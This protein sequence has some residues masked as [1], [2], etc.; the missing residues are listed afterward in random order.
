MKIEGVTERNVKELTELF[1]NYCVELYGKR[2]LEV[3]ELNGQQLAKWQIRLQRLMTD[4]VLIRI[5]VD[6]EKIVGFLLYQ[7]PFE[8]VL[9]VRGIWIS[10]D[11]RYSGIARRLMRSTGK[12]INLVIFQTLK[13]SDSRKNVVTETKRRLK[14]SEDNATYTWAVKLNGI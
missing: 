12:A 7:C 13:N 8:S 2:S 6:H 9:A 4:G 1:R 5:C 10:K 14:V 11:H 3:V